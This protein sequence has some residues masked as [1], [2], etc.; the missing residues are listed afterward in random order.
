MDLIGGK[1]CTMKKEIIA[2]IGGLIVAKLAK[3]ARKNP[4]VREYAVKGVV[5]GI[6]FQKV[7]KA[8]LQDIKEEAEDIYKD[9]QVITGK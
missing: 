8:S 9:A 7:A 2:F 3:A 4:K 5:E 6:K 1:R